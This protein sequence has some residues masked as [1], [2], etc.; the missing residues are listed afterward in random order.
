MIV[1]ALHSPPPPPP[2]PIVCHCT[3]HG[4]MSMTNDSN[5]VLMQFQCAWLFVVM[6][7]R[8]RLRSINNAMQPVRPDRARANS[9]CLRRLWIV[10][11]IMK[12]HADCNGLV[13][14]RHFPR[15]LIIFFFS[16]KN[17]V[18]FDYNFTRNNKWVSLSR[19]PLLLLSVLLL[20]TTTRELLSA[21]CSINA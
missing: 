8:T 15:R 14:L 9:H 19:A 2:S 10:I 6:C 20:R 17:D 18:H 13:W 5:Q 21:K 4:S 11:F 12:P 7:G 16:K 1:D 3:T